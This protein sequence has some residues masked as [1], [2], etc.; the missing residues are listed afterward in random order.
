MKG[1][2]KFLTLGGLFVIPF[3]VFLVADGYFFPYITGKNFAFRIIVEIV[4]ASWLGLALLEPK[5]RPKKSYIVTAFLAFLGIMFLANWQ[6]VSRIS[7]FVSN[8]E[9]M[10]G[11]VTLIHVF[12]Y[13]LV[14]G[15]VMQT[16]KD[17]I[18]YLNLTSFI[19]FIL[20]LSNSKDMWHALFLGEGIRAEGSLGNAAYLAIYLLFHIFIVAWLLVQS[21]SNS[22]KIFYGILI[23]AFSLLL[24]ATGTRGTILGLGAGFVAVLSY[25]SVFGFKIPKLRNIALG[26]LGGLL[27]LAGGFYALKDA[28]FIQNNYNLA[29]IANLDLG[30]DLKVRSAVWEVALEGVKEKPVLGWGQSN[31][32]FVFNK[33][34]DPF[35]FDQEQ[36]FDRTHDIFLD[37]LI[38]G[39][40]FGL[41]SYLSIFLACFYYLLYLPFKNRRK[42]ENKNPEEDFPVL[43][44]A[45]LFG[46]LVGYFVHNLVVFDNIIS[47]IFF[48]VI[49][50]LI[51]NQVSKPIPFV[52]K[53]KVSDDVAKQIVV[54]VL[55][56]AVFFTYYSFHRPAMAVAG[57]IID[58][59]RSSKPADK[60]DYFETALG[61]DS[62]MKQEIV[63]QM[64]QSAIEIAQTQGVDAEVKQEFFLKTEAKMKELIEEKPGDAR[65]HIFFSSFYRAYGD[66]ENAKKEAEIARELSPKKQYIILQQGIIAFLSEDFVGASDLFK[67]AWELDERND[68]AFS[69]YFGALTYSSS[70]K[71]KLAE[72]AAD[73]EVIKKVSASDFVFS[74]VR[75]N[76]DLDLLVKIQEA[77]LDK[78]P[79]DKQGWLNL[80]AIYYEMN[81]PEKSIE[82]LERGIEAE[83]S[84][85][86]YASCVIDNLKAGKEPGLDC[87]NS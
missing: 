10:D 30:E 39:G 21:K 49:L 45:V 29:R 12:L 17:W 42:E 14:L 80:S 81:E 82:V 15:S 72:L 62:F 55:A 23:V 74:S 83:P 58:A 31:F 43:E 3:L 25:V 73:E 28:D 63:E 7:S 18:V 59:A 66:L 5:Y 57:D 41:V 48:A 68:D 79:N 56:V 65:I 9:R 46:L 78:N 27:V 61:R 52:E 70:S 24:V 67:E 60:L 85:K 4:T 84:I 77:R 22:L 32:N 50:A 2:L 64:T 1:F 35:L 69:F 37:W 26:I 8:F 71:E 54:P 86:K 20:F 51:H 36:W 76:N 75:G 13:T 33:Y 38:A 40:V 19:A 16:K 11:Y 47:Y 6:G 44:R 53:L 34:F 87:T